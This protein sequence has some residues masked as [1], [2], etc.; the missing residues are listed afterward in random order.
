MDEAVH[1]II[2][3]ASAE[4]GI[5]RRDFTADEIRRR[6]L[7]AI[8]NEAALLVAE[9]VAERA[10]D[11]DVVLVNGYGFPRWEGGPVFWARER[12]EGNLRADLDWLASV[13][14]PGFVRSDVQPLLAGQA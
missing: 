8:V 11:V 6:A 2:A 7:L 1:A 9:G 12:G 5:V 13:S 10:T 14:G 3:Q 4:K